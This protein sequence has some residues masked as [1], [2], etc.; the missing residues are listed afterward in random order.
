MAKQS[1]VKDLKSRLMDGLK[2]LTGE[3]VL[4]GSGRLSV[5]IP[6]TDLS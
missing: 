6:G 4:T 3:G 2:V 5:R 1:T